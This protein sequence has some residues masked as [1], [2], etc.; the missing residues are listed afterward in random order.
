MWTAIVGMFS[1]TMI[2]IGI[3]M[4][5]AD[6]IEASEKEFFDEW[7]KSLKNEAQASSFREKNIVYNEGNT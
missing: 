4:C 7:E 5:V 3:Y 1:Y 6:E 2:L